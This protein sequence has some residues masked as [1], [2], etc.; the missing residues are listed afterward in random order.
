LADVV[1]A[2]IITFAILIG[3]IAVIISYIFGKFRGSQDALRRPEYTSPSLRDVTILGKY[4]M[5]LQTNEQIIKSVWKWL[6]VDG[7]S[8]NGS[9]NLIEILRIRFPTQAEKK[10]DYF[11]KLRLTRDGVPAQ[12]T[13]NIHSST[14]ENSMIEISTICLPIMYD[15]LGQG[16]Q[17]SFPKASVDDAQRRCK[18]FTAN[19]M[20]ILNAEVLVAPYVESS[21]SAMKNLELLINTP[22]QNNINKKAHE[23]IAGSKIKIRLVGWIDREFLGDLESAKA[24]GIDIK[25]ITK[26]ADSSDKIIKDDFGRLLKIFG[27]DSVRINSRFHDRFLICDNSSIIGSMYFVDASK[28][29]YE[30]DT[31]TNDETV[32]NGLLDH[33]NAIWKDTNSKPPQ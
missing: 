17:Y 1:N 24:R 15:K 23:L 16:V 12:L 33:F 7:Y 21:T 4:R 14:T 13:M 32:I 6:N 30:S 10:K 26:S 18:D 3:L 11:D 5:P 9:P 29:R 19:I 28:T 8:I 25:V 31:L 22:S 2:L 20:C 27:K